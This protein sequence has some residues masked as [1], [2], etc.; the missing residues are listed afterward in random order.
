M[1]SMDLSK[2]TEDDV[3]EVIT[4]NIDG[5]EQKSK[6][7]LRDL[8]VV[9]LLF[10]AFPIVLRGGGALL[11]IVLAIMVAIAGVV[12][13]PFSAT[14]GLLFAGGLELFLGIRSLT[15]NGADS[16]STIG[17]G[18]LL[19]GLGVATLFISIKLYK[20]I[21]PWIIKKIK[22]GSDR[23]KVFSDKNKKI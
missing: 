13:L 10:A 14:L 6:K 11:G 5:K 9:I 18:V 4:E 1:N 22:G 20:K 21:I 7:A 3:Q 2:K 12:M 8:L 17:L 23:I 15:Q 16:I 19:L